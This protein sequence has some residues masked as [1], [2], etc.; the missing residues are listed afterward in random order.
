MNGFPGTTPNSRSRR[1]D[2]RR[3]CP[4]LLFQLRHF[5]GARGA[6]RIWFFVLFQCLLTIA[7]WIL[8]PFGLG[9]ALLWLLALGNFLPAVSV[10][11]RRLH[12]TD[13]SGWWYWIAFVPL[14]GA[15][16]LL[17]WVCTRGTSGPNRFGADPLLGD[18][19]ILPT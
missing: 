3:G 2:I 18:A 16:L 13:H 5:F 14:V 1:H 9:H 10:T 8:I 17:I 6:L 4:V 15:I 19:L 11:V 7:C 12:D